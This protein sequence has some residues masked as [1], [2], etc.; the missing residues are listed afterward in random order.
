MDPHEQ[1]DPNTRNIPSH[2][3]VAD[4][5]GVLVPAWIDGD[6]ILHA[7]PAPAPTIKDDEA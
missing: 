5:R 6:G 1:N 4:A 7:D 2:N 3:L